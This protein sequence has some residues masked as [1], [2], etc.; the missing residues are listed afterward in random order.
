MTH[1]LVHHEANWAFLDEL[2]EATARHPA[3]VWR[4]VAELFE[5][6]APPAA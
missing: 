2:F 4:P 6:A 1:H 3:V 5:V